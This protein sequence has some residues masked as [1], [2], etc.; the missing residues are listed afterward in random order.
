[1]WK[2]FKV[3]RLLSKMTTRT[4]LF[5]LIVRK[6]NSAKYLRK[7]MTEALANVDMR[8]KL[9]TKPMFYFKLLFSKRKA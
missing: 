2:E 8:K 3:S 9:F 7:L 5:N 6:G 4:W 1:M